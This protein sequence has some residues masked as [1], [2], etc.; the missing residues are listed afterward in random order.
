[1]KKIIFAIVIGITVLMPS[2][3]FAVEEKFFEF[4]TDVG[5][6]IEVPTGSVA[7]QEFKI[8]NDY[9]NAV[10]V[11]FDNTGTLGN[12][13]FALLN[14]A[15]TVLASRTVSV[16]HADPFYAGQ[17]LHVN[18]NKT[19]GVN[20]GSWYKLRITSSAAKLRLY[21]IK[22]VQFVEHD[23]P[24]PIDSAVGASFLNG[25]DQLAV[26]KFALYEENDIE[27]PVITNTTSSLSGSDA[28]KIAFN[29]SELADYSLSY[30]VIGSG[31]SALIE[32]NGNY[33]IC[34][35]DVH[36][37]SITIDT[38]RNTLYSYRLTVRDSWGNEAYVD[39]VFESWKPGI[40]I[41]PAAPVAPPTTPSGETLPPPL[42]SP[43]VPLAITN[44]RV[45]SVTYA[46]VQVSW[47]TDR[48]ANS[49]MIISSDPV[50]TQTVA[51]VTDGT[52]ELV[53][54]ISTGKGLTANSTY[55]ATIISRDEQGVMAAQVIPFTTAKVF[56]TPEQLAAPAAP[57]SLLQANIAQ[58]GQTASL[59][60]GVPAT[61]EPANGYRIDIID[62]QGNLFRTMRV[63]AGA[64]SV[65]VSGLTGG[66]YR[67][68]AY[69]DTNGTVEKIA[70]AAIIAVRKKS[71]PIDTYEL[72]KKPIVFIPS[73]LFVI[74]IAGLYW[75]SRKTKREIGKKKRT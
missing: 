45:V 1:M 74:L 26:F 34:F 4:A 37:C 8:H 56:T 3:S 11:W 22:R 7:I 53:H 61:G 15:G 71:E 39:G 47:D 23:A 69:A 14:A 57:T 70:P 32:F 10:D 59:T 38:Q 72:V 66:E 21:G 51:N 19:I 60:W 13:T 73:I 65:E 58:D 54:T 28:V 5:T 20:S 24:Y 25:E 50:G 6:P 29:A 64:H 55:Y 49:A 75:Y 33:S 48:A 31:Q 46:S 43:G 36:T 67:A 44:A 9:I 41:P 27:A 68:I 40:P 18:F 16:G 42:E 17:R 52:Y 2:A 62:E 12:A 63:S 30:G 35:E